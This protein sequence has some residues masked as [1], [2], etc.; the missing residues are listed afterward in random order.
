L[1]RI[2]G[3]ISSRRKRGG[4]FVAFTLGHHGP[5]HSAS[6]GGRTERFVGNAQ[7]SIR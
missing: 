5:S 4:F 7:G 2:S 1:R 3:A 6:F